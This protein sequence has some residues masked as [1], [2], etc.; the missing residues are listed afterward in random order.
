MLNGSA[1]IDGALLGEAQMAILSPQ[2]PCPVTLTA[3][4]P[5]NVRRRRASGRPALPRLELCRFFEERLAKAAA[6]WRAS[7]AGGFD[8]TWFTQPTE[9][10]AWI[11]LPGDPQPTPMD[12]VPGRSSRRLGKLKKKIRKSPEPLQPLVVNHANWMKLKNASLEASVG[13]EGPSTSVLGLL[14]SL[15]LNVP[16]RT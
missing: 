6:D 3:G 10:T 16:S 7:I 8:G 2:R 5:H 15:V 4:T 11:P 14:V 12:H 1:T 13:F 9:E